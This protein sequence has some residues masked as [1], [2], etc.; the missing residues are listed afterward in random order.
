MGESVQFGRLPSSV[1]AGG[2]VRRLSTTELRIYM[3]LASHAD[4]TWNATP[5][6]QRIAELTGVGERTVQRAV[7]SLQDARL[8]DIERGGGRRNTNRYTLNTSPPNAEGNPVTQ[9]VTVSGENPVTF[10]DTVSNRKPRQTK[11]ET[12]SEST[13]NPV[14]LGVTRTEEQ[15]EQSAARRNR[16]TTKKK[17][18][19]EHRELVSYFSEQWASKSGGGAKYGFGGGKDAK[20]VTRILQSVGGDLDRAKRIIDVYLDSTDPWFCKRGKTLAILASGTQLPK[21]IAATAQRKPDATC[22]A[23]TEH[24]VMRDARARG[25]GADVGRNPAWW[26]ALADAVEVG[27]VEDLNIV[28]HAKDADAVAFRARLSGK[29]ESHV[30]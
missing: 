16:Q 4:R 15:K 18:Q 13:P 6:I 29:V 8:I 20:A 12:P 10:D 24:R 19:S 23:S 21:F 7:N 27:R 22:T 11:V 28:K 30:V 1:V 9:E 25:W 3:V 2:W 26:V 5:G 14:T 17:T